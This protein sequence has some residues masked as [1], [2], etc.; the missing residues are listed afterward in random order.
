MTAA[1]RPLS[2]REATPPLAPPL[3]PDIGVVGLVTD[4]WTP[5]FWMARH[6]ILTRLGRWFQVAWVDRAPDWRDAWGRGAGHP[7]ARTGASTVPGLPPGFVVF[8]PGRWLPAVH[9]PDA[10]RRWLGRARLRAAMRLLRRRGARRI[11][12]YL[13]RPEFA[14]ALRVPGACGSIY[15]VVDEYTFSTADPPVSEHEAGL[16]RAVDRVVVHTEALREKRGGFNPNTSL[17]PNGV[18][19][20]AF[21]EP[22]PIPDDLAR[23]PG[24]R[25]G[26]V[27][28]LKKTLDVPLVL[29]LARRHRSW[30]FVFV[31]R[32]HLPADAAAALGG[33]ANIHLLG[34]RTG[35][36]LPAYV[37]HMDACILPYV[38]DGYTKYIYPLKLHEYLAAGRPIVAT[39]IRALLDF[40]DVI[41]LATTVE[42]WSAALTAT[43]A[44]GADPA[45]EAQRREV[46]RAHDWDGLVK[47]IAELVRE[48]AR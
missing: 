36:E 5:H 26:Y 14:W 1:T 42:E 21:A 46:A 24:P 17:I 25:V 9:R 7:R 31:G 23:I 30:S 29:D 34:E 6:Q 22:R 20:A 37:Q 15:H 40:G 39:P 38:I 48:L 28:F 16:L 43:L 33:H 2:A 45:A 27:G 47:Q 41:T 3:H 12:Y 19:F 18:D 11:V 35:R 8:R 13:W 4:V 10:L 44:A 32:D